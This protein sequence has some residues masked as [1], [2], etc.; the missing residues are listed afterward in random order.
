MGT[1]N[2]L[3]LNNRVDKLEKSY[4][5]TQVMMSDGVTSVEDVVD[6][7]GTY[8]TTP[9][10]IGNW[11]GNDLYR[12]VINIGAL[13]NNSDKR[14]ASGL[15][16]EH[17]VNIYGYATNGG[18]TIPLPFISANATVDRCELG[19]DNEKHVISTP[20]SHDLSGFSGVV[21]IEYYTVSS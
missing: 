5:A 4:P 7:V 14:V 16:N 10:K 3:D 18:W 13:P 19:Y 15:T 1:T 2:I 21:V 20:T 11:L 9:V 17:V 6:E 8:S 12:K